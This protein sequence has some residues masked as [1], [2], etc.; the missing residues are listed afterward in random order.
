MRAAPPS[1]TGVGASSST[2]AE[3]ASAP[4]GWA[5]SSTLVSAAGRRGSEL[6]MSSQPQTCAV[7]A[8]TASQA[9]L[10]GVG[11]GELAEQRAE[12]RRAGRR[13]TPD[14]H[15]SGPASRRRSP[16]PERSTSRKPAYATEV[17]RP[18][19]DAE[20]RVAAV[21]LAAEGAGH[22]GDAEQQDRHGGDQAGV[23]ALAEQP[24][25]DDGDDEHLQVAE[26]GGQARADGVDRV[27]PQHEVAGE[28]GAGER[29]RPAGPARQPPERAVL[30][31][32]EQRQHGHGQQAAV[33]RGGRRRHV[34]QAHQRSGEG[35]AAR[36]EQRGQHRPASE[37]GHAAPPGVSGGY[38]ADGSRSPVRSQH[39]CGP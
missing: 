13:P 26:D 24:P 36:A 10:A 12:Q 39:A 28:E 27:V 3:T 38:A 25:G 19:S 23:R 18:S 4:A 14:A 16:E 15:S 31:P 30:A 1:C 9:R 5:S 29:G 22:E 20:A 37:G 2:T 21:R 32:G 6:V 17:A 35:D 7:S 11:Q 34:G 33:E 8:S